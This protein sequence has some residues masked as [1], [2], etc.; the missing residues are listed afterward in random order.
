MPMAATTSSPL[1]MLRT[2]GNSYRVAAACGFLVCIIPHVA[3]ACGLSICIIPL[4]NCRLRALRYTLCLR[5]HM[6]DGLC[7]SPGQSPHHI[8]PKH[9]TR[10][11]V[12]HLRFCVLLLAHTSCQYLDRVDSAAPAGAN[13]GAVLYSLYTLLYYNA[14]DCNGGRHFF[15]N[16]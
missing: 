15:M 13:R 3:A 1:W 14:C 6:G 8:P 16:K 9:D 7:L 4:H 12:G 10:R 2:P 5:L 11:C